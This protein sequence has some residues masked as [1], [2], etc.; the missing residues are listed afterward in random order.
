M[1]FYGHDHDDPETERAGATMQFLARI[2]KMP[3]QNSNHKI[4]NI[5][6]HPDSDRQLGQILISTTYF[7]CAQLYVDISLRLG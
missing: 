1:S 6:A 4:H 3:V 2:L 7:F 5:S